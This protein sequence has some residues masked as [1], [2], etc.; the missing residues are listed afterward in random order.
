MAAIN[1]N[2]ENT[3]ILQPTKF[4]LVFPRITTMT[5]FLQSFSIPDVSTNPAIQNSPFVDLPRPGD[6]LKYG[7]L[8]INF[9]VDEDMW[10]YQV[11]YDWIRGITFPCSFAEY[12]NLNRD[13]YSSVFATKPQYSDGFLTILSGLNNPRTKFHFVNIFPVGLSQINFDTKESSENVVTATAYFNYHI[14]NIL[15]S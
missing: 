4:Q 11:I 3:N 6:K 12:K 2:P 9:I 7:T 5:Y 13:S 8:Q 10:A 1:R 15:R 14:F